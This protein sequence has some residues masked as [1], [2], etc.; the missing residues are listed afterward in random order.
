MQTTIVCKAISNP[1]STSLEGLKPAKVPD[2]D[3]G[4]ILICKISMKAGESFLEQ[5]SL[6]S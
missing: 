1:S 4:F 2:M 6:C 3:K 5:D